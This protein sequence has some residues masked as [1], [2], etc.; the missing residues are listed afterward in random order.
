MTLKSAVDII[1]P[2]Q[3][4]SILRLK[5]QNTFAD[6]SHSQH[7]RLHMPCYSTGQRMEWK[8]AG[9]DD[10]PK[11]ELARPTFSYVQ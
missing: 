4:W 10:D 11:K 3:V 2:S 9:L 5:K 7:R 6:I 8:C 1:F